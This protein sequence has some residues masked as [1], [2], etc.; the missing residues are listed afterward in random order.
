MLHTNVWHG[1]EQEAGELLAAIERNCA[2]T[3]Q[4]GART[5]SVGRSNGAEDLAM[6]ARN[7]FPVL[8]PRDV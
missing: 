4:G 5:S 2:C 8:Q 1:T 7:G 3:H 6:H